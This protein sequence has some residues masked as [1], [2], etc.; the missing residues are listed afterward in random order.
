MSKYS[1]KKVIYIWLIYWFICC[2]YSVIVLRND[3]QLFK[4][5]EYDVIIALFSAIAFFFLNILIKYIWLNK[6]KD[7]GKIFSIFLIFGS[8]MGFIWT[9]TNS[10][11]RKELII[12]TPILLIMIM[13]S[14]YN[15]IYIKENNPEQVKSKIKKVIEERNKSKIRI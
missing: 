14:I 1:K 7:L 6:S 15:Y 12:F 5:L 11:H 3:I 2:A 13:T 8:S 9:I 10:F 4:V